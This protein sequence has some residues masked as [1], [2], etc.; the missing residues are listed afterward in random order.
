[1]RE[2]RAVG[3]RGVVRRDRERLPVDRERPVQVRDRVAREPGTHGVRGRDRIGRARDRGRRGGP[4]RGEAYAGDG[5]AVGERGA[6][7]LV[8]REGERRAVGLRGVVRGDRERL[9][10]DRERDRLGGRRVRRRVA[11][12]ERRRERLRARGEDGAGGRAIGER[13]GHVRRRVELRRR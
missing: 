9:L 4:R 5:V 2:R 3:L 8:R 1:E 6:R 11:R 10:V 7:E 13:A 12:R